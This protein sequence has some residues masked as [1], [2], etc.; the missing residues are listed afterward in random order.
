[1]PDQPVSGKPGT[2]PRIL[3]ADNLPSSHDRGSMMREARKRRAAIIGEAPRRSCARRRL[4]RH[5]AGGQCSIP[6]D[7]VN[8]HLYPWRT[9]S[10]PAPFAPDGR[11]RMPRSTRYGAARTMMLSSVRTHDGDRIRHAAPRGFAIEP[12]AQRKPSMHSK[13]PLKRNRRELAAHGIRQDGADRRLPVRPGD[14]RE[15]S[16]GSGI[17]R[18]RHRMRCAP[19]PVILG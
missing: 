17:P 13:S 11:P 15:R 14:H 3:D 12:N 9:R 18:R 10:E 6:R 1:M 7:R 8:A 4:K 16:T 19:F 5:G 2:Q